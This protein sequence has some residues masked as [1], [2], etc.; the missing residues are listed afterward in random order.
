[1][2]FKLFSLLLRI[3]IVQTLLTIFGCGLFQTHDRSEPESFK[4]SWTSLGRIVSSLSSMILQ[5]N[6]AQAKMSLPNYG[7]HNWQ[8]HHGNYRLIDRFWGRHAIDRFDK[9]HRSLVSVDSVSHFR[10]MSTQSLREF[11]DRIRSFVLYIAEGRNDVSLCSCHC[12]RVNL[13]TVTV[14]LIKDQV[15]QSTKNCVARWVYCLDRK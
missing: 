11:V 15:G 7:K 12:H 6:T 9:T 3:R 10:F 14:T 1:M 5:G 13:K 8:L 4:V 2:T